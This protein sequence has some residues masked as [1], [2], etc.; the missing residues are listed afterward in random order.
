MTYRSNFAGK[1]DFPN[2][3]ITLLSRF[4]DIARNNGS[5]NGKIKSRLVNVKPACKVT[6]DIAF[7]HFETHEFF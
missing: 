2:D 7:Y 4:L 5:T 3:R 1:T 6:K